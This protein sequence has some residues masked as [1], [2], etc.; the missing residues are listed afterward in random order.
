MKLIKAF[1]LCIIKHWKQKD[2]AGKRYIWHPI[3][4]MLN[5][6]GYNEKIVALLHDV[7]EDTDITI[8]DLITLKFD[9]AIV[10]AID[11]LS[12]KKGQ[13]YFKYLEDIKNNEI[14]CKV[15]IEDLKHNSNLKRLSKV[16]QKDIERTQKYKKALDYL[17]A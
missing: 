2:K 11:V 6:K 10:K 13:E 15:K 16:K 14:A 3:Y 9:E 17:S 8:T 12:K 5:V 1:L 4:V 7:V